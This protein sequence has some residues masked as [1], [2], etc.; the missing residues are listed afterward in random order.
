MKLYRF[1]LIVLNIKKCIY[2]ALK[3]II[4]NNKKS[5]KYRLNRVIL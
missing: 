3:L 1:I 5:F 2:F 4:L